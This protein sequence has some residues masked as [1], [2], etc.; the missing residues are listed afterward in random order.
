MWLATQS[1][2]S[3]FGI[4]RSVFSYLEEE[5]YEQAWGHQHSEKTKYK[6]K[7][8]QTQNNDKHSSVDK[9]QCFPSRQQGHTIETIQAENPI[10]SQ[11]IKRAYF[12]RFFIFAFLAQILT[13]THILTITDALTNEKDRR[14]QKHR[15]KQNEIRWRVQVKRTLKKR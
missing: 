11:S 9:W 7:S 13:H 5:K 8:T 12:F 14:R 2:G 4:S 6:K 3:H 1:T 15:Q 10:D